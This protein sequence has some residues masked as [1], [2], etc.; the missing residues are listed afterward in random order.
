MQSKGLCFGDLRSGYRK[1]SCR[2]KLTGT[3][4]KADNP[5]VLH[6][7]PREGSEN[8]PV[9][10]ETSRKTIFSEQSSG[11]PGI[12][13]SATSTATRMGAG[14]V[15]H[16]AVPVVPVNVKLINSDTYVQTYAC[17][18]SGSTATFCT[19]SLQQS[20]NVEG[21]NGHVAY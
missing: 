3:H 6:V 19:E 13:M 5:S 11:G 15:P 1:V 16:E 12:H 2:D 9:S 7:E 8:N 20:L 17:L 4:C 14:Y 10:D 21:K 18:D